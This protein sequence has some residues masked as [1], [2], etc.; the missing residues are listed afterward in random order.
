MPT[1]TRF[2]QFLAVLAARVVEL[3][4]LPTA[5]KVGAHVGRLLYTKEEASRRAS[6]EVGEQMLRRAFFI[7]NNFEA[8]YFTIPVIV[9][10]SAR[11]SNLLRF[12]GMAEWELML[13]IDR[14]GQEK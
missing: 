14:I 10:I 6:L 3:M 4:Y 13:L 11:G 5:L 12:A 1:L 8:G 7:E 9:G 2:Q